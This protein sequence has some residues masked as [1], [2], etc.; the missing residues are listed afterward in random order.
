[1]ATI[2]IPNPFTINSYSLYLG[3][4][5][6]NNVPFAVQ[7]TSSVTKL[8]FPAMAVAFDTVGHKGLKFPGTRNDG[9][10]EELE[11]NR[12]SFLPVRSIKYDP[13]DAAGAD[14]VPFGRPIIITL[15]SGRVIL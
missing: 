4:R 7:F 2:V 11:F 5:G 15:S 9:M 3:R 8:M 14:I 13:G 6:E 1:M 10:D 12:V